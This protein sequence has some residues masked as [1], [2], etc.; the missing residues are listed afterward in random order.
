MTAGRRSLSDERVAA[1]DDAFADAA[2][3][4]TVVDA[5]ERSTR[6]RAGRATGWPVTSWISRLR[7]DPLK[8]LHLDLGADGKTLTG[9]SRTSDAGGRARSSAPG[10][11]ARCVPWLTTSPPGWPSRGPTPCAAPRSPGLPEVGDRLDARPRQHRSRRRQGADV[12]RCRPLRP[13]GPAARCADRRPRGWACWRRLSY[14]QVGD[15][16]APEVGGFPMPTAA[17]PRRR[18]AR[19]PAGVAEPGAGRRD[20]APP[21][22]GRGPTAARSGARG[23]PTSWWSARSRPSWPRTPRQ[24]AGRARSSSQPDAGPSFVHSRPW[25]RVRPQPLVGVR[26]VVAAVP[27]GSCSTARAGG[28]HETE[29][30]PMNESMITLQGWMGGDVVVREAGRGDRGAGSGSPAPRVATR[31]RPTSGSTPTPSGTP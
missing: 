4:P 20:R 5:V 6:L 7:P 22:Q 16:S 27:G 26:E 29:E 11:T 13:V 14:L 23:D 3:V 10:S 19:H 18:G 12:G 31:R 15:P 28:R 1:L 9:R 25:R 30:K 24:R 2:G 21:C 8:R 17:A